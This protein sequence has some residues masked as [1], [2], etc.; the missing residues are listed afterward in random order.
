MVFHLHA[1]DV[2]IE[3]FSGKQPFFP[4]EITKV[5]KSQLWVTQLV[6]QCTFGFPGDVEGKL[7]DIPVQ[8]FH[9]PFHPG[10][11]GF[12]GLFRVLRV[13]FVFPFLVLFAG[14]E[15]LDLLGMFDLL[16][17]VFPL[18]LGDSLADLRR[19]ELLVNL[20]DLPGCKVALIGPLHLAP[21]VGADLGGLGGFV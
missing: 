15:V 9:L 20:D 16:L 4:G 7:E 11:K 3:F 10:V 6:L 13:N 17:M 19:S 8:T 1:L 5:Q 2:Q 21:G 18:A 14:E 12:V